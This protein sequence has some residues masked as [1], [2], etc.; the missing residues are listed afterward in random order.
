MHFHGP[1]YMV[2]SFISFTNICNNVSSFNDYM[3]EPL[4]IIHGHRG[5]APADP[6]LNGPDPNYNSLNTPIQQDTGGS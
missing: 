2:S 6:L 3:P 1:R 5:A 4:I